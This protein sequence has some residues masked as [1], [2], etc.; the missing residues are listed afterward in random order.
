MTTVDCANPPEQVAMPL[1]A[2]NAIRAASRRARDRARLAMFFAA[3]AVKEK[4]APGLHVRPLVA[5]LFLTD[6][7]NLR[8]VSCACWRTRTRGE[9]STEEWR[10]VIDQLAALG[11]LKLNF[12]GG[13]PLLRRDAVALLSYAR[14]AG[15]PEL[16]LNTNAILLDAARM[17][18]VLAAG[19]RSFNVSVDASRSELHDDLRGRA[20]AFDRTMEA[21]Q[22][23]VARRESHRLRIRMNFTVLRRNVRDLPEI[24]RLAQRLQVQL[25]LNL[26][27]DQ[28]FHFRHDAVSGEVAV[29]RTELSRALGEVEAIVRA[30]SRWLP[31]FSDLRYIPKHFQEIVQ[32]DLPCAESQLKLMVHSTGEVGGCWGHGAAANVRTQ[33]IAAIIDHPDYRA[34]QARLFRKDCVGCGSNYSLNLRWRPRTYW[35]NAMFR[36]GLTSLAE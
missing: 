27:S 30:D 32:K 20:G 17:D 10:G 13:E 31:R 23:L 3:L 7:C 35:D 18:E 1:V 12:T 16:H 19:V 8:C 33:A 15:V 6:N 34:L 28:T 22:M 11:F 5:E 24:A 4:I 29:D 25:Y 26:G 2:T 36:L 9:L 14:D 21:L